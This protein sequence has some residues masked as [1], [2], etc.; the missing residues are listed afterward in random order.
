M[1]ARPLVLP[2]A[3]IFLAGAVL[4]YFALRGWDGKYRLFGGTL[5]GGGT[6]DTTTDSNPPTGGGG[7]IA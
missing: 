3:L 2:S 4:V 7:S 5:A 6:S 1:N